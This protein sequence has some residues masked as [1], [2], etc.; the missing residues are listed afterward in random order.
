MAPSV[1]AGSVRAIELALGSDEQRRTLRRNTALFRSLMEEADFDLLPGTHP[2]N[3]VMFPGDDGA[4]QATLIADA[5]LGRGVYVIPFSYPVVP[6][7]KARV[8]VQLSAAHTEADVRTCV[9]AFSASRD[10]VAGA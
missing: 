9:D 4:R 6:K 8:R 5:M 7:G 1:A 2:I 10:E 3:P